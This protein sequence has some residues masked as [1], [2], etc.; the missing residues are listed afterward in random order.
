MVNENTFYE[1]AG[2]RDERYENLVH[3]VAVA[4]PE[5]TLEFLRWL[6]ARGQHAFRVACL[7]RAAAR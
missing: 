2:D 3:Q 1:K 4:D 6:R 7:R 5:W